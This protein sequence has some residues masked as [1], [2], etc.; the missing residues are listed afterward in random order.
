[1]EGRASA[2]LDN[3]ASPELRPPFKPSSLLHSS[4]R[5]PEIIIPRPDVQLLFDLMQLRVSAFDLTSKMTSIVIA[6][7]KLP[8]YMI[9]LA[10]NAGELAAYLPTGP[11]ITQFPADVAAHAIQVVDLG[12]QPVPV[13]KSIRAPI[14]V[15]VIACGG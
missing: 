2:S 5:S 3:E 13:Q 14:V 8:V 11:V 4:R 15:L 12:I 7:S 6:M 10:G 9:N 1:M